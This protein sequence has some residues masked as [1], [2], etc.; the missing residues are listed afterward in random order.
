MTSQK[1]TGA[2][3]P[4]QLLTTAQVADLMQISP[5]TVQRLAKTGQLQ[6]IKLSRGITRYT[7]DAILALIGKGASFFVGPE[8]AHQQKPHNGFHFRRAKATSVSRVRP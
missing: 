3:N 5:R 8:A 2:T 4:A 1:P 6:Q 7:Q